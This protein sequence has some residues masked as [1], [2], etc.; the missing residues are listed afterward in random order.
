MLTLV[1]WVRCTD[2]ALCTMLDCPT[3]VKWV[4]FTDYAVCTLHNAGLSHSCK[5]NTLHCT[6]HSRCSITAYMM[7]YHCNLPTLAFATAHLRCITSPTP[8]Y[9]GSMHCIISHYQTAFRF[10]SQYCTL[11]HCIAMFHITKYCSAL[12]CATL[13]SIAV[14]CSALAAAHCPSTRSS[15]ALR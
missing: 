6:G 10:M 5:V 7:Q 3:L 15:L 13:H 2:S 9:Y 14:H 12:Y 4:H 8:L 11:L 1:K